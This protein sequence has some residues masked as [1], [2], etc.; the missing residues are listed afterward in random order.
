M[1]KGG[2]PYRK[3]LIILRIVAG[4]TSSHLSA[5]LL[6]W[7]VELKFSSSMSKRMRSIS[8]ASCGV[9]ERTKVMVERITTEREMK[10]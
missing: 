3:N 6:A 2:D 7:S 10:A 4:L 5:A 1:W 9:V 8:G